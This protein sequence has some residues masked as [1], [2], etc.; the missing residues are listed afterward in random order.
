MDYR[1]RPTTRSSLDARATGYRFGPVVNATPE[2]HV[3]ATSTTETSSTTVFLINDL[4]GGHDYFFSPV[5]NVSDRTGNRATIRIA[6]WSSS[7]MRSSP[8]SGLGTQLAWAAPAH[9][10]NQ[11]AQATGKSKRP[12]SVVARRAVCL[13]RLVLSLLHHQ[14]PGLDRVRRVVRNRSRQAVAHRPRINRFVVL[15]R[16][17]SCQS[18]HHRSPSPRRADQQLGWSTRRDRVA[19][20][21]DLGGRLDVHARH[22]SREREHLGHGTGCDLE[23]AITVRC[24]RSTGR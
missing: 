1:R 14:V 24:C 22:R 15:V 8:D 6:T 9:R 2:E 19:E 21:G 7:R 5:V 20:L 13:N 17:E 12:A 4:A 16:V 10:R 23:R 3:V 11:A 18:S